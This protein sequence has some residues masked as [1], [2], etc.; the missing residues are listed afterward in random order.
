MEGELWVRNI[1]MTC[2]IYCG[3]FFIM[4]GLLNTVAIAYRVRGERRERERERERE[5]KRERERG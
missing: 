4:F 5:R 1:L 2:F 3:P